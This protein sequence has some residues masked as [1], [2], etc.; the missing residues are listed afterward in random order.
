M[1][2]A[3]EVLR[4]LEGGNCGPTRMS[5]GRVGPPHDV[6]ASAAMYRAPGAFTTGPTAD[7]YVG[8]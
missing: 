8:T 5:R 3:G 7:R 6:A 4:E 2:G 1:T